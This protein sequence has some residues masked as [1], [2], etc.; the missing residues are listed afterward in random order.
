MLNP[1]LHHPPP[2]H[3][4]KASWAECTSSCND[5][6]SQ[7][8]Q[9]LALSTIHATAKAQLA[10]V[11]FYRAPPR[12]KTAAEAR[13]C[14]HC[15]KQAH[16]CRHCAKQAHLLSAEAQLA[17]VHIP[18]YMH[19]ASSQPSTFSHRQGQPCN[20]FLCFEQKPSGSQVHVP[21]AEAQLAAA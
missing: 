1:I 15:A 16:L 9:D 10:A 7:P 12:H 17:A 13:L 18:A 14:R 4:Q 21:S 8:S 20:P 11:H 5:S 2:M 6:V 3:A 19:W